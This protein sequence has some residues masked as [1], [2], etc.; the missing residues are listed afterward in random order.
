MATT[1]TKQSWARG[2]LIFA[3]TLMILIGVY[4]FF[5]GL[6]AVVQ[7]NFFVVGPNYTYEI[8]TTAWGWIHMGIG[9]LAAVTG[10]FLFTGASWAR[11]VGIGLLVVSAVANFFFVPYYPLWALLLI[12][13][14]IFAIWAVATA[15]TVDEFVPESMTAQAGMGAGTY[16]GDTT[17][18]GERWPAENVAGGRHW[19]PQDV[20]EGAGQTAEQAQQQGQHAAQSAGRTAPPSEQQPPPGSRPQQ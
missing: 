19:A 7:D 10:F 16:A 15:R 2:G 11:W 9:V 3:A 12:A 17:Q 8:D 20:K 5:V 13:L 18:T 1:S 6:A 4:Q 14:D